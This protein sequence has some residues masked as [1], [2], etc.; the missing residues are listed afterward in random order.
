MTI[1]Q[2]YVSLPESTDLEKVDQYLY[3]CKPHI[4]EHVEVVGSILDNG[5][6]SVSEVWNR[7]IVLSTQLFNINYDSSQ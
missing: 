1:T 2:K 5:K 6:F 7:S 3:M 4:L